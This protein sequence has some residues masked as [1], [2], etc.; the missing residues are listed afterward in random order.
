MSTVVLIIVGVVI[1]IGV[2]CL[3]ERYGVTGKIK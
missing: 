2:G 3:L 1:L